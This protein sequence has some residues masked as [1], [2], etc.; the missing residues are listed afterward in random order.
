[1]LIG[2]VMYFCYGIRKSNLRIKNGMQNILFPCIE[3]YNKESTSS[4]ELNE[5]IK[6]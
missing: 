2:F 6:N 1:L 5:D 4:I 3:I